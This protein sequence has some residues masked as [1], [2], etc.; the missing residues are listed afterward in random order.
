MA[1]ALLVGEIESVAVCR[2]RVL[3]CAER[4]FCSVQS[5]EHLSENTDFRH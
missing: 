4:E 1:V 2:E 5:P 3:Q